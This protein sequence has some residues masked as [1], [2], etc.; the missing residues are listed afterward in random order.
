MQIRSDALTCAEELQEFVRHSG[1]QASQ[2]T[3]LN[4]FE[5]LTFPPGCADAYDA[6]FVGGSSDASVLEPKTYPFVEPAKAL[7][8]HCVDQSLP[9]FASCFGFQLVVEAL[10]GKVILDHDHMEMGIYPIRLTPAAQTDLLFHDSP[11]GFLAVSGHKERAV[12]LPPGVTLLAFTER[13]PYHAIKLEGKP[14][15]GFQFHPEVDHHDLESRI[16]RYQDR[17]LKTDGH[18]QEIL[19]HLYPTP[20]ANLLLHKFVD[21][22][23][24]RSEATDFN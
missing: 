17:Y 14:F 10:G 6:L 24:L 12:E 1:L 16:S 7:L 22:V 19:S 9:V 18:L 4:V 11:D 8:S 2:F 3:T 20:E 21:R 13:C 23:L 5:Q 15:Y